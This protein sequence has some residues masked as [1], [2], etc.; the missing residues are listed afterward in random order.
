VKLKLT[1]A[2]GLDKLVTDM[3]AMRTA[4]ITLIKLGLSSLQLCSELAVKSALIGSAAVIKECKNYEETKDWRFV[5]SHAEALSVLGGGARRRLIH[6]IMLNRSFIFLLLLSGALF[7]QAGKDGYLRQGPPLMLRVAEP[8]PPRP[9]VNERILALGKPVEVPAEEEVAAETQGTAPADVPAELVAQQ[10]NSAA[11]TEPVV[12]DTAARVEASKPARDLPAPKLAVVPPVD[13]TAEEARRITEI[14]D[15]FV[16]GEQ[17]RG[18]N[19][20]TVV[21]APPA[22]LPPQPVGSG[23]SSRAVYRSP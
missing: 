3:S 21:V 18:S 5:T 15:I 19:R 9:A 2:L 8:L 22:F 10:A 23:P 4:D 20:S 16:T 13:S 7:A 14:L 11:H 1:R 6:T 17:S 12:V